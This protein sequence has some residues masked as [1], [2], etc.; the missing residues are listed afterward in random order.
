MPELIGYHTCS[1]RGGPTIVERDAPYLSKGR[2]NPKTN[3]PI[4]PFLGRGYY[5]WE[6]AEPYVHSKTW[7]HDHYNNSYYVIEFKVKTEDANGLCKMLDLIGKFLHRVYFREKMKLARTRLPGDLK[8]GKVIDFLQKLDLKE[9]GD[10]HFPFHIIRASDDSYFSPKDAVGFSD[11]V[12]HSFSNLNREK[13]IIC[14]CKEKNL[15]LLLIKTVYL[16]P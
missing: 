2:I 1:Q 13:W 8:V 5:F 10:K 12:A 4:L 16:Y 15:H 3:R 9:G 6:E 14:V 7:G 11:S